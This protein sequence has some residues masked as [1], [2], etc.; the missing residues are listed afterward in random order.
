MGEHDHRDMSVSGPRL[1]GALRNEEGKITNCNCSMYF[2]FVLSFE[3]TACLFL[4]FFLLSQIHRSLSS[5]LM[6]VMVFMSLCVV[7]I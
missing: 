5:T 3:V 1:F 6:T 7:T 2:F 4:Y